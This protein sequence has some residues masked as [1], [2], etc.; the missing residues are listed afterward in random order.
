MSGS[1][2][3]AAHRE[4]GARNLTAHVEVTV[5]LDHSRLASDDESPKIVACC[6][7][8]RDASGIIASAI[9]QDA[10]AVRLRPVRVGRG[11]RNQARAVPRSICG[12]VTQL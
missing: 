12:R 5:R 8:C 2:R 11:T 7:S 4:P 9:L 10:V 6:C 1:G 3:G